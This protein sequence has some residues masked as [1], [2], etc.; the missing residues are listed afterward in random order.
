MTEGFRFLFSATPNRLQEW[1][2]GERLQPDMAR[3]HA[4]L[5]AGGHITCA[6]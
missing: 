6:C 3:V 4:G 1:L 2:D 5:G